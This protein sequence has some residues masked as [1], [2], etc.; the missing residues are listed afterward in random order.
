MGRAHHKFTPL[1][2]SEGSETQE[3]DSVDIYAGQVPM[4]REARQDWVHELAKTGKPL[5]AESLHGACRDVERFALRHS[6]AFRPFR[7]QRWND[8]AGDSGSL[9]H[10][11]FAY[12]SPQ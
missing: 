6:L 11:L 12:G 4:D 7:R 2:H 5:A 8:P 3:A 10:K 9:G 1:R